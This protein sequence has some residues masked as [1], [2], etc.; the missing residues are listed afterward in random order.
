M[1]AYAIKNEGESGDKLILRYK[2]MIFQTRLSNKLK[3]ERYNIRSISKRKIREKA[4]VREMYRTIA[5][6][7]VGN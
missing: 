1:I 2:K 4:I 3:N 7:H 6:N 5:S